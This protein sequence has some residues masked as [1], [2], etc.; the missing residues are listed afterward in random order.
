MN[1]RIAWAVGISFAFTAYAVAQPPAGT[2]YYPAAPGPVMALPSSVL[3]PDPAQQTMPMGPTEP[4]VRYPVDEFGNR[5]VNWFYSQTDLLFGW[6][7]D[8]GGRALGTTGNTFGRGVLG[9]VGTASLGSATDFDSAFGVRQT[10][11]YWINPSRTFGFEVGGFA[12]ERQTT[13]FSVA[14]SPD[15]NPVLAR[16]FFDATTNSENA[17]NV[18]FPGAFSGRIAA[19][20]SQ[21]I[22]GADAGFVVSSFERDTWTVDFLA[23]FKFVSLIESL[24]TSDFSTALPNGLLTYNGG[25]F[26]APAAVGTQDFVSTQNRFYGATLGL[27]LSGD[28]ERLSYSLSGR[29]G[30]GGVRQSQTSSGTTTLFGDGVNASSTSAGGMLIF[31]ANSG[32]IVRTQ[33]AALPE[34]NVKLGYRITRRMSVSI[35]YD[36]LYLSNAVRPGDAITQ[37]INPSLLPSGTNFGIPFGPVTPT[38]GINS[39]N[40]LLQAV[41]GGFVVVF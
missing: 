37:A 10:I 6:T 25:F 13:G 19:L 11:G 36:L 28:Y 20:S 31:P 23:G 3:F 15:G 27:R 38:G 29:C 1:R 34:L 39:S 21:R 40:F 12:F 5:A 26:N 18:A 8:K 24:T 33:F 16:P 22:Y 7:R 35:G 2:G 4:A 9:E 41:S 14:S 30:L 32:R 17:R